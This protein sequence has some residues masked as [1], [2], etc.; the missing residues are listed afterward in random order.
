MHFMT[1]GEAQSSAF[2]AIVDRVPAGLSIQ[3]QAINADLARWA[4]C[5]GGEVCP[6]FG[7]RIVAGVRNGRTTGAPVALCLDNDPR[8]SGVAPAPAYA[9][10]PQ[11]P[12]PGTVDLVGSL[13]ADA[14]DCVAMRER[15]AL[16]T[17]AVR[18]AAA[19]VAREFLADLGVDVYSYVARI[20]EAAMREQPEAFEGLAYTPLDI[21]TSPV[22]CPSAQATR[23]MEAALEEAVAKGDTLGGEFALIATGVDAGLGAGLQAGVNAQVALA[24]ALFSAPGVSGVE[25]GRAFHASRLLGTDAADAIVADAAGFSRATNLSGGFE[26]GITTGMPLVMRAV[27]APGAAFGMDVPSVDMATLSDVFVRPALYEPCRVSA[28]S[29]VAEAEVAFALATLYQD[30]FG[31]DAMSDIHASLKAYRRRLKLAAR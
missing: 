16:R 31:G 20:G 6:S 19:A 24:G 11:T 5:S 8:S 4:H 15:F 7:A 13:S 28:S 14:D 21:E 22:R 25:F 3:E 23:L 26:G 27:V 9:A 17:T 2:V 29:V 1:A 30:K 12:Y 10:N 18:V